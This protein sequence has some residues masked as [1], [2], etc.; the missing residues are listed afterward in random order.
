MRRG[1][2][3]LLGST[4]GPNRRR[5][6]LNALSRGEEVRRNDDDLHSIRSGRSPEHA[7]IG[8]WQDFRR[9]WRESSGSIDWLL[10]RPRI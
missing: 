1:C 5:K 2:E 4:K 6:G 7:V 10:A 9:L 3:V 8:E